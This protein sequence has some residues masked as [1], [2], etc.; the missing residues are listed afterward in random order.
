MI[1]R[2]KKLNQS[3]L[4]AVEVLVCFTIVVVIV[5]S[6]TKVV[7]NQRDKQEIASIKNSV[8]TYK[9][10][11]MKSIL[12]DIRKNGGVDVVHEIHDETDKI[13]INF[14]VK[15]S[16]SCN[17]KKITIKKKS[18]CDED[19]GEDPSN[20]SNNIVKCEEENYIQYETVGSGCANKE[21]FH[22][23]N[24]YNLKFNKLESIS[25]D[26][27]LKIYVGFHH[28][29]LGNRYSAL[30]IIEPIDSGFF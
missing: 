28:P 23:P 10:T 13:E 9:N 4:T 21:I 27:Y 29:D 30:D 8:T 26:D 22:I 20:S 15:N 6:M 18:E 17:Q 2:K 16:S 24:V 3:G 19:S 11:V 12:E 14:T 1:R 25:K 5:L 7:N